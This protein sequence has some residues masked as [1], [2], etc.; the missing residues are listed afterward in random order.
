MTKMETQW[1]VR[2]AFKHKL[3]WDYEACRLLPPFPSKQGA[4]EYA[5]SLFGVEKWE[6]HKLL[7]T[8][9]QARSL[10]WTRRFFAD[11]EAEYGGK[12][13]P[14]QMRQ[15]DRNKRYVVDGM[16]LEFIQGL[17][18]KLIQRVAEH[19]SGERRGGPSLEGL[20]TLLNYCLTQHVKNDGH[21]PPPVQ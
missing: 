15:F 19:L 6:V 9:E 18:S 2:V 7:V 5:Q 11:H 16:A 4:E 17:G 3:G 13:P 8:E 1:R 12:T 10:E 21:K 14:V 20:A